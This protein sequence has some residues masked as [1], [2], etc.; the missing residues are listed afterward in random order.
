MKDTGGRCP[1][2]SA[3][4]S[5]EVRARRGSNTWPGIIMEP[6]SGGLS[7]EQGLPLKPCTGNWTYIES[8][9]IKCSRSTLGS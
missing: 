4:E 2:D 1:G 3:Y 9:K 6:C 8:V 7:M 5:R